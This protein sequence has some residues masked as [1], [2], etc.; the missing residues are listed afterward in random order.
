MHTIYYFNAWASIWYLDKY[1]RLLPIV[2]LQNRF[3]M[4][5]GINNIQVLFGGLKM[6]INLWSSKVLLPWVLKTVLNFLITNTGY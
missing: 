4:E 6:Y 5:L 3:T 2:L 1:N